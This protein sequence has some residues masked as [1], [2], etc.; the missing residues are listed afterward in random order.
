MGAA[1]TKCCLD[2]SEDTKN[3]PVISCAFKAIGETFS[4]E[5]SSDNDEK[6]D[7]EVTVS[8]RERRNSLRS[9]K[10]GLTLDDSVFCREDSILEDLI[11]EEVRRSQL[12][13]DE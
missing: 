10:E 2:A 1:F 7:V 13:L 3:N 12:I 5:S 9:L 6:D 8:E 11:R 4:S